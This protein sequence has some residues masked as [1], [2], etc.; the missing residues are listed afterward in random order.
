M[1]GFSAS[2]SYDILVIAVIVDR[3]A[4]FMQ[5]NPTTADPCL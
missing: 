5:A 2:R 4:I 1:V 3:Q